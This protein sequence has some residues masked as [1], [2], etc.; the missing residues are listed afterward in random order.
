[1]FRTFA[2][3]ILILLAFSLTAQAD[4]RHETVTEYAFSGTAAMMA[5]ILG[6]TKPIHSAEYYRGDF[7]RT[8][9]LDNKGKMQS[10][11]IIDLQREMFITMDH[12]KKTYTE[13]SFEQW[14]RQLAELGDD[15]AQYESEDEEYPESDREYSYA[16]IV[17]VSD[18]PEQVNGR[19]ATK[20]TMVIE[21]FSKAAGSD[22]DSVKEMTITSDTWLTTELEGTSE[23]ESFNARLFEKL[24]VDPAAQELSSM[25]DQIA[26]SMPLLADAIE[27]LHEQ[28]E[29]L[30]GLPIRS[31]T[32]FESEQQP[33]D[34]A[35]E[36]SGGGLFGGLK[37]KAASKV[38]GQKS[39]RVL[40]ITTEII[41]RSTDGVSDEMF[42]VPPGYK[43]KS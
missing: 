24:G 11:D 35:E 41:E 32:V 21:V 3:L 40:Q 28:G 25:L 12:K 43:L 1:M 7:K 22:E 26:A 4:V 39:S 33:G 16:L 18:A 9:V 13:L 19:E 27:K 14:R 15:M 31:V 6:L 34:D 20:L 36:Q 42:A 23:I 8:D 29:Q 17:E 30:D 37:K 2:V 5:K 38:L 10:S